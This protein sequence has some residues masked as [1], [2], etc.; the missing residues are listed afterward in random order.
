MSPG[1]GVIASLLSCLMGA[2]LCWIVGGRRRLAGWLAFGATV[3]SSSLALYA[4]GKAL[5]LGRVAPETFLRLERLGFGLTLHIDGLS[6]FFVLLI[7]SI[8]LPAVLFSIDYMEHYPDYSVRRYYPPLL[9]F[10][11]ALYGLVTT[12]DMMWFFF[13]FWQMMTLPGFLLIRFEHRRP[14][15]RR[16]AL[17]FLIMMEIACALTMIGAQILADLGSSVPAAL[18]SPP[19]LKYDFATVSRSLPALLKTHPTAVAI[20]FALFL[21]GFGIKLGMWPFGQVWLPDAHPAAPSPMSAMLSGVMLKT[22]VYGIMRYFLW[23][24]PLEDRALYPAWE[25]GAVMVVLGTL[26][27][28]TGTFQAL[29]QERT[30]RLLAFHSIGQLGY[31]LFGIGMAM[32]LLGMDKKVLEPLAVTAFA[33][34]LLHTL[35]HATFKSLLFLNAGSVLAATDTQDLNR[36]G[37]LLRWMPWTGVAALIASLSISGVP[38]LNGFVSKWALYIAGIEGFPAASW[39]PVCTALAILTGAVTLV[40]FLKFFG[41]AF[42]GRTS[43]WVK[44]KAQQKGRLEV[45]GKMILSQWSL[46]LMCLAAGVLPA[47]TFG[48]VTLALRATHE[49]LGSVFG[50]IS[51]TSVTV[52]A[53]VRTV[54]NGVVVGALVILGISVGAAVAWALSRMGGARVRRVD[55][56]LCGYATEEESMRYTAHGFYGELKRCLDGWTR[57]WYRPEYHKPIQRPESPAPNTQLD[58]QTRNKP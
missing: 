19:G 17:K 37:S 31:I 18:V 20:A 22:G 40:S 57:C 53:G 30:K 8:A 15:N 50:T 55:P 49:G 11:A 26:T 54:C 21:C 45:S 35:H 58:P 46:A 28:L 24:I 2:V 33:G 14:E 7:A 51:P 3:I 43:T 32:M 4:S 47:V 23:V 5:A 13:I 16:A 41:A 44:E 25:W 42:L 38:G 10:L 27:L 9:I 36:L 39:L 1:T 34:A 12:T 48:L 52:L 56:W 29:R 6:A